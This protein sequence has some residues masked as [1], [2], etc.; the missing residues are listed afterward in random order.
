MRQVQYSRTRDDMKPP[1]YGVSRC[2]RLSCNVRNTIY[3]CVLD[4][5]RNQH[6]HV[7]ASLRC[8]TRAIDDI[9]LMKIVHRERTLLRKGSWQYK[10]KMSYPAPIVSSSTCPPSSPITTP[11]S[12]TI[13]CI[14]N[15]SSGEPSNGGKAS[16]C[17]VTLRL[18]ADYCTCPVKCEPHHKA[19]SVVDNPTYES[20]P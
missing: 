20:P 11:R 7:A 9:L 3:S 8:I 15:R 12:H 10:G 17:F 1:W 18:G 13:Y 5:C 14:H 6:Q 16:W 19:L 4:W 2:L